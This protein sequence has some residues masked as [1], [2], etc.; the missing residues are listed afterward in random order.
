MTYKQAMGE[1]KKR[2]SAQAVKIYRRHGAKGD[3]YGVSFADLG[4]MKKKIKI[5]HSL[6]L[7][8]WKSGNVDA[9]TLA[10]MIADPDRFTGGELDSWVGQVDYYL[11]ADLLAGLVAS[12]A[13]AESR[14][15]KWM[16]SKK[17]F[18]RQCGYAVLASSLKNNSGISNADCETILATIEREI[19][20]SPNRA[21]HS[22]NGA[23][24][25]IGI[26]RPELADIAIETAVRIGK[27]EVDHGQT[28]C[29]T[30]EAAA[31][32]RKALSRKK[33]A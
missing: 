12:T 6:A 16:K 22:M 29:K 1:L 21:R 25:A 7:E 27:V 2:G 3:M 14:M 11:L 30:P 31:Y 5:D 17:E 33:T 15:T 4:A 32:I 10:T 8:L 23:I 20:S 9:R 28:S 26:F 13:L 18:V 24:S 19:H